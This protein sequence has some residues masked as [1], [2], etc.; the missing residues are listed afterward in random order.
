MAM[1][2]TANG[3]PT[4]YK[5]GL[6]PGRW[7]PRQSV[8]G[9]PVDGVSNMVWKAVC[10]DLANSA[11]E[12]GGIPFALT[13]I[14]MKSIHDLYVYAGKDPFN[15]ADVHDTM[16]LS[17]TYKLGGTPQAPTLM[18]YDAVGEEAAATTF[19]GDA[20]WLLVGGTA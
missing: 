1:T 11:Y 17:I 7:M 14:G 6:V 19:A 2:L 4:G 12:T 5:A 9:V 3:G 16:P 18:L 13:D 10:V 15:Q 8:A 20:V